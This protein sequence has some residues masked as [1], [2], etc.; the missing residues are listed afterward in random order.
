MKSFID[1]YLSVR[2]ERTPNVALNSGKFEQKGWVLQTYINSN[3][4]DVQEMSDQVQVFTQESVWI[5]YLLN[6]KI[7]SEFWTL[8]SS[9]LDTFSMIHPWV[10][11]EFVVLDILDLDGGWE[12]ISSIQIEKKQSLDFNSMLSHDVQ[13]S[14]KE[15][16]NRQQQNIVKAIAQLLDI[17]K[18]DYYFTQSEAENYTLS[19][20][21]GA[22]KQKI[23]LWENQTNEVN[24]VEFINGQLV[25]EFPQT[26][27][28]TDAINNSIK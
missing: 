10:T 15:P 16:E 5:R 4:L 17:P 26:S 23:H 3:L 13:E 7:T 9:K 21:M 25:Q 18:E 1:P 27:I 24:I 8:F 2:I 28:L 22:T 6:C 14:S 12:E 20:F 19:I 11:F